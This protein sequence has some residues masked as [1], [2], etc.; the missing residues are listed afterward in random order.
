MNREINF[1]GNLYSL[2]EIGINYNFDDNK[3][4]SLRILMNNKNINKI[5]EKFPELEKFLPYCK[6][7]VFNNKNI[8]AMSAYIYDLY[9]T[10]GLLPDL[11]NYDIEPDIE[12]LEHLQYINPYIVEINPNSG[13]EFAKKIYKDCDIWNLFLSSGRR[14]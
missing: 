13:F 6:W 2:I 12:K 3:L 14:K 7:Y 4:I 5:K 10:T 11:E 9:K 1:F 8:L